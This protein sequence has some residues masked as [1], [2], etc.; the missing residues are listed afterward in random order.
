MTGGSDS[1]VGAA[2][3]GHAA[4]SV[5][6][7]ATLRE[8]TWIAAGACAL[9]LAAAMI[10]LG[11]PLGH[12][13]LAPGS[14]VF[15][16]EY[17]VR[18]EPVEHA[19]YLIALLG[20]FMVAAAVVVLARRQA[21]RLDPSLIRA[22]TGTAQVL[23]SVVLAA[24]LAAENDVVVHTY[25]QGPNRFFNLQTL[26]LALAAPVLLL[27]VLRSRRVAGRLAGWLHETPRRRVVAL[28]LAAALSALWLVTGVD[29]DRTIA[30]SL[31]DDWIRWPLNE[32]FAV[33]NGRTPLVDVHALYGQLAGYAAALTMSLFGA[34]LLVWTVTMAT[35]SWCALVA[36]YATFRRIVRSSLLALALFLPFTAVT[37]FIGAGT[38]AHRLSPAGIFSLWPIRYAGPYLVAW[39]VGRHLDALSPKRA[40]PLFLAAGL[41]A[42]NNPEFGAGAVLGT[43]LA[44][45]CQRPAH[46]S[47]GA[48]RLLANAAAGI[49]G[50]LALVSLLTLMRT[51]QLP[52]PGLALEYPRV[53]GKGGWH[54][55][56]MRPLGFH[57]AAYVTFAA[58][59]VVAAVRAASRSE[60]TLLTGMLAWSGGFGLIAGSYYVG[61]SEPG[62]MLSLF[63]AW[64]FAL[65]LLVVV[66]C[67]SLAARGWRRPTLIELAVLF[68]FAL[69][70]DAVL[71]IPYPWSEVARLRQPAASAIFSPPVAEQA[72][73]E[74]TSRGEHVVILTMLSSRIAY[75]LGLVNIAPFTYVWA[76]P[77]RQM[78]QQ[79]IDA[80][81]AAGV[82]KI[83]V[84]EQAYPEQLRMLEEAG[85]A[86]R[87]GG[88]LMDT[89]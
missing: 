11:P 30:N 51:G 61:E 10:L 12:T 66:V 64:F 88:L 15:F 19:R 31:D 40:W 52:D 28:A 74:R 14:D 76:I 77:T 57:L 8:S 21:L 20:P 71:M 78:M 48:L 62:S 81:R 86:D 63:S 59:I 22:L 27:L 44:L 54:L 2:A 1:A 16:P 24:C 38:R 29:S 41:V 26:L 46:S 70:L 85:F 42:I 69:S 80:A 79:T 36:V 4:H 68:G 73:R 58:A 50:A 34:T 87:G 72:I 83:F 13:F 60:D 75:D 17:A 33:L 32:T 67:R 23:T 18:P 89:S 56:P 53:L 82:H 5:P 45:A 84:D 47:R 43:L 55:T 9:V 25:L 35:I 6:R 37:F 7:T 65:A 3:I 49:F 39:L